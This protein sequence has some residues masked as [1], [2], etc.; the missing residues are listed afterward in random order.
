LAKSRVIPTKPDD[1]E[2]L[3][4]IDIERQD[5]ILSD[6]N[7]KAYFDG[8]H[9]SNDWT[10]FL[11][12]VKQQDWYPFHETSNV[13]NVTI[14]VLYIVGEEK[15]HEVFGAVQYK[16]RVSDIHIAVIPFASHLV[17]D[18]Q[19]GIYTNFLEMFLQKN[20]IT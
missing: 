20:K 13:Q 8:L 17:H 16:K 2:E 5:R 15:Q 12:L 6:E 1:W 14:P 18:N 10:K 7:A 3:Q 4:R 9:E 19:P 11:S